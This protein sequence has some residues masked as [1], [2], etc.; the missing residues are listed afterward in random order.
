MGVAQSW[1]NQPCNSLCQVLVP[2]NIEGWMTLHHGKTKSFPHLL[3]HVCVHGP[4]IHWSVVFSPQPE[5]EPNSLTA[6]NAG[7]VGSER[8]AKDKPQGPGRTQPPTDSLEPWS[9]APPFNSICDFVP[10]SMLCSLK[11]IKTPP[12]PPHLNQHPHSKGSLQ[13]TFSTSA[14]IGVKGLGK[15]QLNNS[16]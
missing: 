5:W 12:L 16:E 2:E 13:N 10:P 6:V 9:F 4:C 3:T 8:L 7:D 15:T 1:S 11:G 14:P